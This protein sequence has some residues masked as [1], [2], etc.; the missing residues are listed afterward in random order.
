MP[1]IQRAAHLRQIAAGIRADAGR[2]AR[3]IVEEQGKVLSLAEV[4]VTF[5][6]DYLDYT[7]EWARRIEGDLVRVAGVIEARADC[8]SGRVLI[9][10]RNGA[11][12][13]REIEQFSPEEAAIVLEISPENVRRRTHRASLIL[14]GFLGH[15]FER[16]LLS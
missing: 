15:L 16:S 5:T 4:E 6:A 12:L 14:T 13:L 7:A 2:I 1:P 10:Y 3:A 8:H 11:F 9:R